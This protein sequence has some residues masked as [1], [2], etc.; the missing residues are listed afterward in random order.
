MIDDGL[1]PFATDKQWEYYLA[2]CQL[3][4]HVAAGKQFDVD[5][6]AIGRAIQAIKKKAAAAG[7]SPDHDMTHT[8]PA[9]FNVKGTST[10]YDH[11]GNAK[12]Q[13][14][15]T[16]IDKEQQEELF[17]EAMEAFKED[18]PKYKPV[19]PPKRVNDDLLACYPVGDHHFG[20]LSWAEETGADYDISI[21]EKLLTGAMDHLVETAPK[22]ADALIVLLG[23]F[24]HY[25]S[26]EAVTPQ[27]RNQLDSDTRYQ[28]MVRAAIRSVRY[29]IKRALQKHDSVRLIVEIGNHDLV[30]S[31]WLMESFSSVYENEPRVSV[32]VSPQNI[33]YY[34]FG[35]CLVTTT[36]GDK[37]KKPA[38]IPLIIA[39]DEPD[40][41][42]AASFRF[43]W[44]GHIH[45]DFAKDFHGCKW[46]SFRILPPPDAY[47]AQH[48]YRS[49]RD[50]KCITLH[51]EFGEVARHIV[52][53]AMLEAV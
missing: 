13:W 44:T 28:R 14:V 16:S 23:D 37:L 51:K 32:D 36:H 39:T 27:N 18:L 46:E 31:V 22:A 24:L 43:I 2:A 52:N 25:D 33:H 49:G 10:L 9:G 15:K 48:G 4:S 47:A 8:A 50:M 6:S 19:K 35:R 12:L 45:H 21:G 17:R 41:W 11:E 40:K 1:R 34:S 38:D 42:A 20:M 3:G 30:G 29:L 53:P 5:R 7:Y 26:M